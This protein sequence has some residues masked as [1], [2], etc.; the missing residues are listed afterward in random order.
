MDLLQAE[1]SKQDLTLHRV[2]AVL[3]EE[4][5]ALIMIFFCL[6]FLQPI[7]IPGLST[8]LGFMIA[9]VAIFLY[10]RKPP[11]LPKR[12]ENHKISSEVVL[13]VSN[14]AERIWTFAAKVIKERWA[15]FHDHWFFRLLNL[16]T[17]VV[18]AALLS[19]PLPIPF[20]N[21]VP[22]IAIILSAIGH[23]E[24]DGFF[25]LASYLWCF[26]VASFFTTLTLGAILFATP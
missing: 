11:Q 18:N 1:A 16:I 24:K 3:G 20:S 8:P 4:G 14:I 9:L 19:L 5:H 10:L 13:K 21:T 2:F 17:I 25:I 12:F 15:F 23:M 6:P 26:L 7:P 22:V